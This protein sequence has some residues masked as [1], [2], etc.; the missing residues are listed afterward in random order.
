MLF[1]TLW[2]L[3]IGHIVL[4]RGCYGIK[5]VLRP[6]GTDLRI[7]LDDVTEHLRESVE[8]LS[9]I[10]DGLP[11]GGSAQTEPINGGSLLTGLISSMLMPAHASQNE[12]RPVRE[13]HDP[14]SPLPAEDQPHVGA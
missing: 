1:L 13:I 9:Y 2:L 12:V 3:L 8:V 5:D 7:G 14:P 4:I 10:A 11:G 6:A